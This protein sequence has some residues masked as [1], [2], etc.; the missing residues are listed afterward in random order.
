MHRTTHWPVILSVIAV[1]FGCFGCEDSRHST[2]PL[3][4]EPLSVNLDAS[5]STNVLFTASGGVPP[6]SWAVDDSGLG[7]IMTVDD[8]A[9]YSSAAVTGQNFVTVTDTDEQSVSATVTQ[10]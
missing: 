8:T 1:C 2:N 6:Y 3:Q 7:T 4:L 9:I 10:H 5:V